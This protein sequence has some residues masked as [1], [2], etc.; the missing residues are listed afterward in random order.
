M[1]APAGHGIDVDLYYTDRGSETCIVVR[2]PYRYCTYIHQLTYQDS[3][4][5]SRFRT[6]GPRLKVDSTMVCRRPMDNANGARGV[7]V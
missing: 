4:A 3:D 5:K 6:P 1:H 2:Y 7:V